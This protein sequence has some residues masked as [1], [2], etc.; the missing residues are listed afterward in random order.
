M[1]GIDNR[2][3]LNN[4]HVAGDPVFFPG[5]DPKK[6]KCML[7]VIKNRGKNGAGADMTDEFNLT[8]W[9]KYAQTAAFYLKQGRCIIVD[10]VARSYS[11]ETGRV[12]ASGK[13]EVVRENPIHVKSFQFGPETRKEEIE[14]LRINLAA[15]IAAG[16]TI[17]TLTPEDLMTRNTPQFHDYNP[18]LAM[19]TGK[20]GYA[21]VYLK[22]IGWAG[23]QAG[24]AAGAGNPAPIATDETAALKAKIAQLEAEKAASGGA[25]VA[26]AGADVNPF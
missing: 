13:P 5:D 18:Q 7:T 23:P 6:H 11:K 15:A 20:Y 1:K 3:S 26:E 19:Q 14:R 16:K 21:R 4:V 22:G 9:G 25:A 12:K 10:G 17:Q 2:I 8:F 24:V